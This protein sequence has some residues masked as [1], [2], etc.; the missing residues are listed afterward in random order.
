MLS[1]GVRIR[2]P[3]ARTRSWRNGAAV[4]SGAE[5]TGNSDFD[6]MSE[7]VGAEGTLQNAQRARLIAML[8]A[9]LAF[10]GVLDRDKRLVYLNQ[11]ARRMLGI[12]PEEDIS[13]M[14]MADYF[15][16]VAQPVGEVAFRTAIRGDI[17][18]GDVR[19]RGR[20][21]RELLLS[22]LLASHSLPDGTIN[23]FSMIASGAAD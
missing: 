2:R 3:L 1:R 16:W 6:E 22:L 8:E 13:G 15:P 14:E 23:C 20:G 19:C 5:P 11:P 10:A 4:S 7:P 12:G 9:S 18:S 21:G 17:W